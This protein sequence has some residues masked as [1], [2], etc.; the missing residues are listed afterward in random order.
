MLTL[1]ASGFPAD[2][3]TRYW[4]LV[5]VDAP[6]AYWKQLLKNPAAS[7]WLFT[8][9][10]ILH[11]CLFERACPDAAARLAQLHESLLPH[12][13]LSPIFAAATQACAASLIDQGTCVRVR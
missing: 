5:T 2:M 11:E 9:F 8:R 13:S 12:V 1:A 3:A 7:S 10:L 6:A 4:W